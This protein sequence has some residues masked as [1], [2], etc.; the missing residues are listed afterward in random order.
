MIAPRSL[1]NPTDGMANL[2]WKRFKFF[3]EA[4]FEDSPLPD[5]VTASCPGGDGDVWLGC[6]DGLV[7][8]LDR[9]LAV[10]ATFPA[11]QGRVHTIQ[12]DKV[13]PQQSPTLSH[14]P[15]AARPSR[16]P[17]PRRCCRAS[18]SLWATTARA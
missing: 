3:D 11:Y 14:L 10:K 9:G 15:R 2:G 18:S 4:R 13:R 17:R 12:V 8:C 6:G 16:L 5:S 7:V 1:R